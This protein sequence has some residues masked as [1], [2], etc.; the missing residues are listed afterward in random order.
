MRVTDIYR[1]GKVGTMRVLYM[2]I[3]SEIDIKYYI[4]PPSRNCPGNISVHLDGG[5]L[6]IQ[7]QIKADTIS[8]SRPT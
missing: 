4:R 5:I 8:Y 3:D 1:I 2:G 6:P 7:A